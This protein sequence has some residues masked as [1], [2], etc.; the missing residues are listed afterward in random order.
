MF[1]YLKSNMDRF[2]VAFSNLLI[3]PLKH[4]KSNMDRFIDVKQSD[5]DTNKWI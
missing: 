3:E 5:T 1:I 4:L 2:I